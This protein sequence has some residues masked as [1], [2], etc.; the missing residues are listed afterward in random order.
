MSENLLQ[1]IW[2]HRLYA[3]L[4]VLK[5]IEG[6]EVI[7]LHPGQL[8]VN[9]G[10]DFL[11][12]RLKIGHTLWAGNIELH[13]K[14]SD[15]N[16]H[17]HQENPAYSK[18]IMH[19]VYEHDSEIETMN[20]TT[21]PTLELKRHIDKTLLLNFENLMHSKTFIPCEEL[22]SQVNELTLHQQITRTLMERLEEKT[23]AI[24]TLLKRYKNNWQEVFYVQL[25]RGFGL[26][27][28]QDAF[29]QLALQTP[30]QLLGK[31]K[32]NQFQV[33]ALLFGQAGF[34][35]DYFDET[36]PMLLQSEYEYLKKLHTLHP[37]EKHQWK[38][39]RL[40]PANFPTLR[41]AQF[42]RLIVDSNHLFSKVLSAET[43]KEI[44]QL[45]K[46]NVSDYW[47]VHY[48]FLEKSIERNKSLGK[49]F[50]HTLI[51]NVIVP[52]LFIYGK[53]QG[54]E[55]YCEKSIRLLEELPAE[56]NSIISTWKEIGIKTDNAADTQGL[57]QLKKKYCDA[58]NCLECS[59]GYAVLRK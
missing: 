42:A 14:S 11:E 59:I 3:S 47:L 26:H 45:F 49:T 54:K 20:D 57:L 41:I 34:L 18:L 19:V 25:A 55:A 29:E 53:L 7:I 32:N 43:I 4:P 56:K 37:M 46:I 22:I 5:T 9:A 44:E 2:K 52:M 38:F 28:N 35:F 31:H 23:L 16:K 30:L 39:L 36:Y 1:F 24:Q 12:A 17:E 40:R 6:D 58:K 27:I 10:P 13:L 48:N 33:E 15:W 50:V 51:I 21:F 8:N